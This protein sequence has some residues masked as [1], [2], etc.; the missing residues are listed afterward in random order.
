M[1]ATLPPAPTSCQTLGAG[2]SFQA[3]AINP[4]IWH[5]LPDARAGEVKTGR[6]LSASVIRAI[7]RGPGSKH[8]LH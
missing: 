1:L 4:V 6:L 5:C 8:L 7:T 3:L 2:S